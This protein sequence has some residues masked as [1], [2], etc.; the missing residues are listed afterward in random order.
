[1]GHYRL[2]KKEAGELLDQSFHVL[3][4]TKELRHSTRNL[5]KIAGVL[6]LF[7]FLEGHLDRVHDLLNRTEILVADSAL[8]MMEYKHV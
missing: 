3:T 8:V 4:S 6:K 2:S 5:V 1:M 7:I